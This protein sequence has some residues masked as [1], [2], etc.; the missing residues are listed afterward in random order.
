[1][2][3][4]WGTPGIVKKC[5]IFI[6]DKSEVEPG[7]Q[8]DLPPAGRASATV[9]AE[10]WPHPRPRTAARGVAGTPPDPFRVYG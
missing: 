2:N 10:R 5:I 9:R 6:S 4:R 7:G 3:V 1:M 8:L